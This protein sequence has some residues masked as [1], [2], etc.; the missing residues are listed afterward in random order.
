MVLVIQA[1]NLELHE[2]EER[3]NLQE[4]RDLEFFS[5]WQGEMSALSSFEKQTLDKV[6]EDFL[7]IAKYSPSEEII[8]LTVLSHLLF[9]AG[10][11]SPPFFP[12]AETPVEISFE[13]GDEV[14]RGRIDVLIL[15]KRLWAVVVEAKRHS[16]NVSEGLAQALFHMMSSPNRETPT[17]S[18]LLNGT[19]FQFVKLINQETPQYGL[20]RL[21]SLR[22]PGNE[23]C[24]VLSIL[25][26]L[27]EGVLQ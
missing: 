3:F 6:K 25:K 23:L 2:V 18:F 26:R 4:V 8:K 13:D 5:E 22:N 24:E 12:K 14:I 20:S 21:F 15:H 16:L 1:S 27:K 17:F 7:V 10:L 9:A 11:T 19:E